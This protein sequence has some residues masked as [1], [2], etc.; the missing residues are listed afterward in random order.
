M[1]DQVQAE[2]PFY[3]G[4]RRPAE[5]GLS[6]LHMKDIDLNDS[7]DAGYRFPDAPTPPSESIKRCPCSRSRNTRNLVVC[8]DGTSNKFGKQVCISDQLGRNGL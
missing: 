4:F 6:D 8:I 3:I 1:S 5:N 2:P 7:G